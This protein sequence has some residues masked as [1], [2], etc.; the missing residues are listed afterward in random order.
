[1]PQIQVPQIPR[2]LP[3]R[4]AKTGSYAIQNEHWRLFGFQ[5]RSGGRGRYN[6]FSRGGPRPLEAPKQKRQPT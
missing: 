4:P 3:P 1:M 6:P 2:E 5:Y